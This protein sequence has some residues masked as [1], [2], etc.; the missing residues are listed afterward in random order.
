MYDD[1]MVE[2][3]QHMVRERHQIWLARQHGASYPWTED[4]VLA[5]R[6]FTNMFR[7]LDPGSQ[8]VFD[9]DGTIYLGDELL[10]GAAELVGE[11]R[12][13]G[14]GVRQALPRVRP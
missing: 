5:N 12:R 13:R 9:L 4:P 11:L 2:L 14:A 7:V 10:P 1:K 3:Y 8:F 6:K